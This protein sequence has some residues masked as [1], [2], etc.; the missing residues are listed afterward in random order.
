MVA[1]YFTV[2]PHTVWSLVTETSVY[3]HYEVLQFLVFLNGKL[4]P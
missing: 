1:P 2:K 3:I 4:D